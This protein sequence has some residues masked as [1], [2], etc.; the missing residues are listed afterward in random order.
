MNTNLIPNSGLSS[1][2]KKVLTFF[3]FFDYLCCLNNYIYLGPL[4]KEHR[5]TEVRI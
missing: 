2:C 3:R 1:N 4:E 5:Q